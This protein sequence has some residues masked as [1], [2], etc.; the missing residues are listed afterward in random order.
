MVSTAVECLIG[1][2]NAVYQLAA[3]CTLAPHEKENKEK[4]KEREVYLVR[5]VCVDSFGLN[6]ITLGVH[7]HGREFMVPHTCS[8][9]CTPKQKY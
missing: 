1:I 3:E 4:E 2:V 5:P 8:S 7:T 6:F 9:V